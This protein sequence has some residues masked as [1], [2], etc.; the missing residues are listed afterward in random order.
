MDRVRFVLFAGFASGCLYRVTV[1]SQPVPVTVVLPPGASAIGGGERV[2]TP[3]EVDFRWV[4]FG[5]Q[6]IVASANGYRTFEVDLR[7]NVIRWRRIVFRTIARPSL[8]DGESRGEVQL[9]LVP[10]HGPVGTWTE[11]DI[12]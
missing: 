8:R 5:H 11:D 12:P 6:R 9:L 1:D 2:S 7:R 3:A 4:P 10:E